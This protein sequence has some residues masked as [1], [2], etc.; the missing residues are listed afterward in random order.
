[1]R[2]L[3]NWLLGGVFAFVVAGSVAVAPGNRWFQA[4]FTAVVT[5]IATAASCRPGAMSL[6]WRI[7]AS[8]AASLASLTLYVAHASIERTCTARDASGRSVVIGTEL[9][10]AGKKYLESNPHDNSD[11]ILQALGGLGPERAWTAASIARCRLQLQA[12]ESLWMPLLGIALVC[13]VSLMQPSRGRVS[14]PGGDGSKRVFISYNHEDAVAARR[15][16]DAL[17]ASGLHPSIDIDSMAPGERIQDFIE[18]SIRESDAVVSIVSTQ[19]LLSSWVAIETINAFHRQKWMDGKLFVGALLSDDFFRPEFRLECTR[20]IDERLETIE[21]LLPGY[22]EKMI[23]TVDLNDE[24]TRLYDL[25]NNLGSILANLKGSLCL[26]L[27]DEH[28]AASCQAIVKAC[29]Q[30]NSS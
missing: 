21:R 22:R 20:I 18:R 29:R 13:A 19:S 16:R 9:T 10:A 11:A 24:K 3:R 17:T 6:R 25:R 27:R 8:I 28:F 12:T 2:N 7:A 5:A 15:L 30:V 1:V 4:F 26:S 14:T 23:D